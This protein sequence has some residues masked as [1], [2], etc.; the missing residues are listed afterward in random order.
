MS[1]DILPIIL[2][3]GGILFFVIPMI[4]GGNG[5][6][7]FSPKNRITCE[8][9]VH[10]TGLFSFAEI[11]NFQC[12]RD[13]SVI[14]GMAETKSLLGAEGS[15]RVITSSGDEGSKNFDISAPTRDAKVIINV[16]SEDTSGKIELF[17]KD[18]KLR[19]EEVFNI[20]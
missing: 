9:I 15:V 20:A 11:K 16:C 5:D 10:D 14:C 4:S 19:D 17:D 3:G 6:G 7:I 12:A 13:K 2:I 8:V 18:G 1:K